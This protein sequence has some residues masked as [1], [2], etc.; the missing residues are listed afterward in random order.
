M[1][2]IADI[3]QIVQ[4]LSLGI[5]AIIGAF[6]GV[7]GLSAWKDQ[8]YGK[9]EYDIAKAVLKECILFRESVKNLR[10]AGIWPSEF[11]DDKQENPETMTKEAQHSRVFEKRWALCV[12]AITKLETAIL[13]AEV[14][15]G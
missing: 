10:S 1:N 4:N 11:E 6:V 8:L 9:I 7:R 3:S 15:W 12:E 2:Y 13:D 14:H 5:A